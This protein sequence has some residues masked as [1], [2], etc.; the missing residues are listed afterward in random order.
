MNKEP[1]TV[2]ILKAYFECWTN[3]CRLLEEQ[4]SRAKDEIWFMKLKYEP[5]SLLQ[6][7]KNKR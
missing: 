4:L 6:E 5:E 1:E 7:I 2:T 3:Q